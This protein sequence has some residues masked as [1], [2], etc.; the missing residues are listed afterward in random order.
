MGS[1]D[2]DASP[3]H[4]LCIGDASSTSAMPGDVCVEKLGLHI[5]PHRRCIAI[6]PDPICS[7]PIWEA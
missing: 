5:E 4:R 3:V 7:H 2:R 6:Y 1:E